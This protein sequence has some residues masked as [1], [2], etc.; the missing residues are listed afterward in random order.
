MAEKLTPAEQKE[1]NSLLKE[2]ERVEKQISINVE[3]A[4]NA[5]HMEKKRLEELIKKGDEESAQLSAKIQKLQKQKDTYDDIADIT[6][7]L[8][9]TDKGALDTLTNRVK[10]N[11]LMA[12]VL[13]DVIAAREEENN[14]EG[15]ALKQAQERR[16]V[17]TSLAVEVIELA[18]K[19][20]GHKS[21]E[22][23]FDEERNDL[24]QKLKGA[25]DEVIQ[26][27]LKLLKIK[28]QLIKIDKRQHALM[29][30]I[31]HAA[32]G[33]PASL[34]GA[35]KGA[36]VLF[37]AVA[38]AGIAMG[39]L[40]L[41]V[42]ILGAGLHVFMD[43]DK[44]AQAFR[45]NTGFTA[46]MTE[47]IDHDVHHIAMGYRQF[48][49]NAEK[50]YK[51]IEE[52]ANA[53]SD[54]FHFSEATQVSMGL[55]NT[56]MGIAVKDSAKVSSMFEQVGKLSE[57][58]AAGATLDAA[59]MFADV[60]VS[61]KEGFEDMA[62]SAGV[63]SKHMKGNVQLFVQQAVKAKMLGTSL[64]D[65]SQTAEKLLDFESGIE[66]ELAAA[67]MVGGQFNLSRARALA[68]EGKI[69]DANEA[70]LDAI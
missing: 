40:I 56:Q 42:A 23:T 27:E 59:K 24:I 60:G 54:M 44:Q 7:K 47:K 17:M 62:A 14:L 21:K 13:A 63:L 43:L 65:L 45:E 25:S 1:L 22:K 15:D 30:A 55:L 5:R 9:V 38:S 20:N 48:G 29:H 67:T 70:T 37:K 35:A 52:L 46:R 26:R 11:N 66:A 34:V 50:A 61:A 36:M 12:S 58:A 28:H 18:E 8:K 49:L 51:V 33:L 2:K 68:Y 10:G 4:A 53:Q 32:H 41:M 39:P 6:K 16:G 19:V 31:Q 69:A 3:K 64:K 57:S